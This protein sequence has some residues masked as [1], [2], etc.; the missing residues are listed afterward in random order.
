MAIS[1][2]QDESTQRS[3]SNTLFTTIPA[4]HSGITFQNDLTYTEAFNTYTYRNFYN[5]GGVG[6]GDVNNDG[7]QDVFFCGNMV[8]NA[9]YLNQGDFKFKDISEYAGITSPGVWTSGVAMVDV[10]GDGWLDIYVTKGGEPGGVN[11]H[12]ELFI[13]NGKVDETGRVRFTEQ[14]KKYGLADEGLSTHAAF[15]DYD[16]DGDLDCYLLANSLRP[17]GNYD[18]R[19]DQ[20]NIRDTLGGNKLY[21][22]DGDTFTDVSEAAGIYGSA[23][24]FGLG[25][26]IGDVNR[27]GWADIYVS[28]DYFE[29]DYLYINN[30][31]GG[32][33]EQLEETMSE[34][35]FSSMGADMADI[36]NDGYPEIFVTDMLPRDNARMK[37]KTHF[38]NWDKYQ[39][40]L[41]NG[42][43]HQFNR[44]VLQLNNGRI[45]KD[46]AA[47]SFSEIGRMAGTYATDWSW[48]A[49]IAD[50]DNDGLKDIFIANGIGKDLTD[51]D[52]VQFYSD[53]AK[54]SRILKEKGKVIEEMV[55]AMPEQKLSNYAF[56]NNGDLTFED[57]AAVWGLAEPSF[58]N[59]SAYADFDNDGDLDLVVNNTNMPPFLY[60]NKAN[61]KGNHWL[62]LD[63][64]SADGLRQAIGSQATLYSNG[65]AY[66]QEVHPMKGFESTVDSRLNFGLG[67]VEQIDSLVI[68]WNS[69][70]RQSF[71]TVSLDTTLVLRQPLKGRKVPSTASAA[72]TIFARAQAFPFTHQE[73]E[74]IDFDRQRLLH[75][76]LSNEGPKAATADV[77]GDGREDVFICGAKDQAGA[78]FLQK[79]N[80]QYA[81]APSQIAFQNNK[82]GEDTDATFFDADGD[83][84][85]DLYVASG[86]S[87]FNNT[88]TQLLDKLYLNDGKGRFTQKKETPIARFQSS[89]CVRAQDFDQDG[90][91]DLFVGERLKPNTYGVPVHGHLLQNN[92]DATFKNVTKSI[93]PQLRSLGMMTDAQWS[94]IDSDGDEDLL[95][96]GDWME[97]TVFE[98]NKGQ[99][100]IKENAFGAASAGFWNCMKLS[101]L[102]GDGDEDIVALNHGI[103]TRF[104]PKAGLPV[105]MHVNDF[106]QNGSAEQLI[107]V[108]NGDTLYP[109]SLLPELTKQMPILRKR[110]L[111]H[112]RYKNAKISDLFAPEV[113]AK[114]V[115]WEVNETRS[116]VY[117]NEG[118]TFVQKALPTAAQL[119]PMYGVAIA[120]FDKDGIKDMLVGGNLYKAKPETGIYD[121]THG[122]LLKGKGDGT[123]EAIPSEESGIHIK[124][125]IRDIE[126]LANN[127]VMVTV[128][129]GQPLIFKY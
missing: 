98:N 113:L 50:L 75:H 103:N 58:S 48:G 78:L 67:G 28:N 119:A 21:R 96:V 4:Q 125:E 5:G 107:A 69:G 12:N 6:V 2:T 15:F 124:G 102:D 112:E 94:D 27:D 63:L 129:D 84:D 65:Q 86:S 93:A 56:S 23:I 17:V 62:K 127:R 76:M 60:E 92:G 66:F 72:R 95:I 99:F 57:K 33:E 44:N 89:A 3:P 29:R 109:L 70:I 123:F 42:Y 37:T 61:T 108:A 35:S 101:D 53:R 30:Q 82:G 64:K 114:S 118:G 19:P 79:S 46:K 122:L 71:T 87:E 120:D 77:N 31:K 121:A 91:I 47:V 85:E 25:V 26:T 81:L 88:A 11:R 36:N 73:N 40:N 110:Y 43:F 68:N 24:G 20:R 22:N 55:D 100:A 18:L 105:T 126:L 80:E 111:K 38:E 7:L 49:L 34:I 39:A 90:D 16:K 52:Y 106:D 14:S 45:S 9:L 116:V 59:G 8:D 104:V 97:I 128:N 74:H 13:N 115:V 1:C 83:G 51:Q 32:F 10:N 117:M 41:K 54:V